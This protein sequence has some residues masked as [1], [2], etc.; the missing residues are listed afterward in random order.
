MNDAKN[1]RL[2][3][4][5]RFTHLVRAG[6]RAVLVGEDDFLLLRDPIVA[7]VVRLVDGTRT[8]V[9]VA[10]A[11]ARERR[12][13]L[14]HYVLL[15]LEEEEVVRAAEASEPP[16]PLPE[17]TGRDGLGRRLADAWRSRDE[18]T[19]CVRAATV[20][21]DLGTALILAEDYL[22]P[23]IAELV[24]R[25][26]R[27]LDGPVLLARPGAHS[28]WVGPRLGGD[29]APCISCLQA[30]LRMNL[31]ARTLLYREGQLADDVEIVALPRSIPR[32][33]FDTIAKQVRT[34]DSIDAFHAILHSV[35]L[36]EADPGDHRVSALPQ[37]PECGDP[38][39]TVPGADV[40]L[41]SRRKVAGS[42]GGF[43]TVTPEETA[44]RVG[45]W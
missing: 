3:L 20:E 27:D 40:H 2:V 22:H 39:L 6:D 24:R 36:G 44:R 5:P 16:P 1:P 18:G 28:V 11:L 21:G 10:R 8:A 37:C 29:G 26:L 35:R 23:G 43:R 14:V 33:A 31:P 38:R 17:S 32:S 25:T 4:D 9:E 30:R 7:A 12:P 45:R 15:L 42:G 13:E 19:P 41:A 34:G